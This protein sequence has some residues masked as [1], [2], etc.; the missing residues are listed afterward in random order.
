[1]TP[2]PQVSIVVPAYNEADAIGPVL[3][4]IADQ[5]TLVYEVLVVVDSPDDNTIP[6]VE[7]WDPAGER[8]SVVINDVA[9]GP[10]GA[11][12]AGF[13]AASAPVVVVT[14]ADGADDPAQI[15]SLAR[16]VDRGVVIAAASR[17]I[18]S[19]QQVGGPSFKKMLSSTAGRSLRLLARTGITDATNSFKAYDK[20]FVE[21]VGI[22]STRGFE[23]GLELVAK[24]R[25]TRQPMAEIPTIWIDRSIGDSKFELMNWLPDYVR[26]YR[27]AFGPQL[28]PTQI[29]T[30]CESD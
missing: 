16:L 8:S 13:K 24:A 12:R 7:R 20:A 22:H 10:A 19:G 26:W 27:F 29:W 17:Y 30:L 25:R 23:V 11:I 5:V 28:T 1:M 18:E 3:G 2:S 15:D 9:P 6:A 21:S 4:R 14:M